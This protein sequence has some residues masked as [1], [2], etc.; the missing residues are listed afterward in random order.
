M[1][2]TTQHQLMLKIV[3]GSAWADGHLE[4]QEL[5]YLGSL[6]RRY[7]LEHDPEL[8]ELLRQP[9]SIQQTEL[10]MADYL[11]QATEAERMQLLGA[12]GNLLIADDNVSPEEHSL[13]DDYHSLMAGIPAQPESA[14]NLVKRVGQFFRRVA[15]AVAG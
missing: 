6:L 10:W 14:P 12:I 5:A 3:A 8:Q 15:K 13:L 1:N 7:E 9:V 2:P 11:A 4:P